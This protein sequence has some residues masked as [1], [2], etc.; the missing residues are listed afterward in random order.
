MFR[1]TTEGSTENTPTV[2]GVETA[3][4]IVAAKKG[5]TWYWGVLQAAERFMTMW[6]KDEAELSRQRQ[7]SFG[8]SFQKVKISIRSL[9]KKTTNFGALRVP[10]AVAFRTAS[11][12]SGKLLEFSV[13]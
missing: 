5:G 3:V 11:T 13:D 6:N 7:A 10:T 2:P 4:W 12:C 9:S 8:Q 1:A